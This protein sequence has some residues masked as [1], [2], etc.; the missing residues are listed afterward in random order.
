MR[1]HIVLNGLGKSVDFVKSVSSSKYVIPGLLIAG[2]IGAFF[3]GGA[4]GGT[5]RLVTG[6][7]SGLKEPSYRVRKVRN[8]QV[9]EVIDTRSGYVA[10]SFRSKKKA[11]AKMGQLNTDEFFTRYM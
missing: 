7:I 1:Q 9:W 2:A 3:V 5:K 6:A 4:V 11:D 10:G 8:K